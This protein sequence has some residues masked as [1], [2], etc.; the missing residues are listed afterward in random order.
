MGEQHNYGIASR[1]ANDLQIH[2]NAELVKLHGTEIAGE[3]FIYRFA[4]AYGH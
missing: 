2:R 4:R 1:Q 3:S